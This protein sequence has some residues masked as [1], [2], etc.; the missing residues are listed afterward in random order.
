MSPFLHTSFTPALASLAALLYAA[1]TPLFAQTD[2]FA[3]VEPRPRAPLNIT[4]HEIHWSD[5][6]L[7]RREIYLL[8]GTDSHDLSRRRD[9]MSRISAGFEIQ[10]LFSTPTRTVA[11]FDY[12][13]RFVFRKNPLDTLSDPMGHSAKTWKYETHNAYLDLY[14]LFGS[15]GQFNL[16]IGYFYP[17]FGLSQQTDTHG[18]LLQLSGHSLFGDSHDW[19]IG[20]YG[21][22]G[23]Q[24]D[25]AI[26]YLFGSGPGQKMAGQ[27]GMLT[28]R[29]T[30]NNNW[31]F[32]Q[33][34]EGGLSLAVGERVDKPAASLSRSV[35]NRTGDD[36]II[37]TWRAGIDLRKQFDSTLGPFTVATETALGED[38]NDLLFSGLA[39]LEWLHPGRRWGTALQYNHF[40]QDRGGDQSDYT[41]ARASGVITRYLRNDI[42]NANLHWLALAI[43]QSLRNTDSPEERLWM[44]QYY[45][46]W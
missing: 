29:L 39:R 1:I 32:E 40:L 34:L 25:Y 43:E 21:T 12:Q 27:T 18:T 28:G 7:F 45:R 17:P 9:K 44:A 19:Q 6:L 11:S 23:S 41:D 35:A 14:N 31:L 16:R 15:Q 33:G 36:D 24:F 8:F 2:P 37:R 30:L 22:L 26:G 20:L 13:G 4:A 3:D 5:N 42:G 46:Y 38:E 10:K